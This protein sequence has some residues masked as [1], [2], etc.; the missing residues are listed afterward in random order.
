M[1]INMNLNVNGIG[2]AN[3]TNNANKSGNEKSIDARGLNLNSGMNA[4]DAKRQ[5]ARK[6]AMRFVKDAWGR[7]EKVSNNIKN[8]QDEKAAKIS[9]VNELKSKTK[10]IDKQKEMLR[11]EYGVDEDSQ[12]YKDFKLLE[13]YQNNKSGASYDEF[14]EDE[15]KRLKELQETPLT[16]FQQKALELNGI[17]NEIDVQAQHGEDEIRAMTS[18]ISDAKIEQEKSQDMLKANDAA[19][20]ILDAA[21]K[22]IVGMLLDEA[23]EHIDEQTKENKE[24]A[25]KIKEEQEK[26]DELLEKAKERREEQEDIIEGQTEVNKLEIDNSVQAQTVNHMD[27]AQKN[28]TKLLSEN[29]MI[30]EDIKGIEI[31]LNF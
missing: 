8:M 28:I 11:E 30:N 29:H 5:S 2:I 16:E 19:E 20:Q 24:K 9:E 17:K 21:S 3:A 18:S 13:K 25:E 12:E 14:S 6:Q 26:K 27:E 1:M 22:D 7:D 10:D 15:I 4:I 23:K 31:D